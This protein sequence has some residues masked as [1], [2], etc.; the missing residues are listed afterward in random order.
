MIIFKKKKDLKNYLNGYTQQSIGFCPTMGALHAGHISLIRQSKIHNDLTV[1]SIF[2]NPTQFTDPKDYEKY[3]TTIEND[4]LLLNNVETDILFLPSKEEIYPASSSNATPNFDFG[5]LDKVLEGKYR[6]GH[7]NGVAQIVSILLNIV[8]PDRLYL[9]QKDYQQYLIIQ[10]LIR[11]LGLLAKITLV[12]IAREKNG[13]AM[14]SRNKRLTTKQK[15][16]AAKIYTV[17]K[18]LHNS[19]NASLKELKEWAKK[20]LQSIPNASLEYFEFSDPH[21]LESVDQK[22]GKDILASTAVYIDAVRLIDNIILTA[23]TQIQ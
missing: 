19:K 2:V 13:L 10:E 12:P 11:Q 1:C 8:N 20:E 7:F 17:L 4:I 18:K 22:N 16:E 9:G 15:A 3:P 23:S 5:N 14:S 6:P 21:T